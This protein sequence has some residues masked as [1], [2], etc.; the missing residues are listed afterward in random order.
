ME[1]ID[2]YVHEVGEHLPDAMRQDVETELR[3]LLT[4]ALEERA[5][6]GS[7]APDEE[8]AARL[9]REFGPPVEVARRYAPEVEYLI[10]PRLFPAYKRVLMILVIVFAAMFLASFVLSVLATVQH[11]ESGFTP[12]PLFG[13]GVDLLKSLIF[14][15]ALLTLA[16]AVV[17]RIRRHREILG[18]DWDPLK[19]PA[20]ASSERISL[21]GGV[22]QIYLIILV[23]V[24]FNFYPQWVGFLVV[25][26]GISVHGILLPQF[27]QHLPAL[28]VFFAA[29]FVYDLWALRV[30][31]R[32]R[33]T[34]WG[35]AVLGLLWA[36]VLALM[37]VGPPVF[38]YD[39]LIKQGLTLWLIFMLFISALRIYKIIV[40]K[41]FKEFHQMAL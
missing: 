31:K 34:Q 17:E 15:F 9:V 16:F 19:L 28:N 8:L 4:D 18:K 41:D 2:R 30:G 13:G 3:S 37:I 14:N 5:R 35:G 23:A 29:V 40:R 20:V 22:I 36:G 32:T 39:R 27:S 26:H 12:S 21:V 11:P 38:R 10:G 24:V 7:H 1:L 6:A 33:E 25:Y